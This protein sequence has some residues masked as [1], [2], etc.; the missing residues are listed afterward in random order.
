VVTTSEEA[1]QHD[2]ISYDVQ[3]PQNKNLQSGDKA[4]AKI[5]EIGIEIE[6]YYWTIDDYKKTAQ[7]AGF[8]ILEIIQPVASIDDKREEWKDETQY[9]PFALFVFERIE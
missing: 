2:W 7:I 3:Y 9:P 8:S 1:Y 6:D 4:K 5:L